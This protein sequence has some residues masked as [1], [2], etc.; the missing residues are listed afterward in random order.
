MI[1]IHQQPKDVQTTGETWWFVFDDD[2]NIIISPF[3]CSGY[4]SSPH[5]IVVADS[6]E[7]CDQYIA[8][9]ELV[10]QSY[11]ITEIDSTEI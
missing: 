4:T 9:N 6:K 8:D 1:H 7:E 3:Q 2:K 11:D 5:T 10:Y